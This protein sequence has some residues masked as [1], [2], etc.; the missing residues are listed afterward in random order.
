MLINLLLSI[1]FVI[2]PVVLT[3]QQ[4]FYS[5]HQQDLYLYNHFFK[6]KYK[7][8]FVDIGAHDGISI[9]N[10]YFFEKNMGWNGICIEPIPEVFASLTANRKCK[11]IQGCIWKD[12]QE[13]PFLRVWGYSEMLSGIYKNYHPE[14]LKR[15]QREIEQFGGRS[16]LITVNCFDLTNLLLANKLTKVDYLSLDTEGGEYEILCSINFDLIDI[17]VITVEKNYDFPFEMFLSSK[18]YTKVSQLGCDEVYK[19]NR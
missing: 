9:S 1:Y 4:Q 10:S 16:E 11:C 14:H 12:A 6:H 5:Q 2:F 19:K 15:I 8:T 13:V 17:D 18:G 7:G 3:A